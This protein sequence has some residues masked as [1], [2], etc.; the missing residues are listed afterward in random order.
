MSENSDGN[1]VSIIIFQVGWEQFVIDLLDV[2]EIITAGQIRKLP[3][4]L[5]YIDGIYNYRGEI[6][7]VINLR[8]KLNLD[9][10]IIY[11]SR[12][13]SME[14]EENSSNT[15]KYIIILKVDNNLIGFYVDQIINID[16]IDVSE[17]VLLSPIFQTSV[18]IEYVKGVINFK[19]RPRIVLDLGKIFNEVEKFRIQ[20]DLSSL[21]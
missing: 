7:H 18:A 20:Q 2:K 11:R 3:K 14:E 16:H 17:I 10:Y 21:T 13:T 1:Q 4:S 19:D 6:I 15:K 8:K 9:E 12:N 5:D